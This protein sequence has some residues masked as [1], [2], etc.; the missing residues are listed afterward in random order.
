M[1]PISHEPV[2]VAA[3]TLLGPR[4][5]LEGLSWGH[6]A[7]DVVTGGIHPGELVVVAARPQIGTKTILTS[8]LR[9]APSELDAL[10]WSLRERPEVL[11]GHVLDAEIAATYPETRLRGSMSHEK[12]LAAAAI[13]G[14]KLVTAFSP[15]STAA[16]LKA[17]IEASGAELVVI[18]V[19]EDFAEESEAGDLGRAAPGDTAWRLRALAHELGVAIVAS[20]TVPAETDEDLGEPARLF[21]L[22]PGVLQHADTVLLVDRAE[23]WLTIEEA[24]DEFLAG[25]T[26]VVVVREGRMVEVEIGRR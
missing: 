1:I 13:A 16:R 11:A 14:R 25:R 17:K 9:A 12:N 3:R 20:V 22:P 5:P 26:Q 23:Y 6:D 8:L 15:A 4:P 10:A 18:D 19:L 21:E 24:E 7:L 2:V